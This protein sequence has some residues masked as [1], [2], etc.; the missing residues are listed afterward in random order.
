MV[1]IYSVALDVET[2]RRY[3][4]QLTTLYA[5]IQLK[6]FL[7]DMHNIKD[8]KELLFLLDTIEKPVSDSD[9]SI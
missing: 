1:E 2:H 6:R 5:V 7:L 9:S 4:Q 8:K 3:E